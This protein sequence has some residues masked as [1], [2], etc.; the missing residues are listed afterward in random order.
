DFFKNQSGKT[1]PKPEATLDM[2][3]FIEYCA[4]EG[5]DA[6]EITSYYFP[7]DFDTAYLAKL[8]RRAALAGVT[9]SGASVAS[10]L[11]QPPGD[12]RDRT[13]SHVKEWLRHASFLGAPY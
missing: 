13:I 9:I 5:W 2:F 11:T 1:R 4:K 12:G 8:K 6:A 10:T 3:Q 7:P